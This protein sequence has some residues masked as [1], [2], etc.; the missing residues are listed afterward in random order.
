MIYFIVEL[1]VYINESTK[2]YNSNS[3]GKKSFSDIDY[4]MNHYSNN[5]DAIPESSWTMKVDENRSRTDHYK[6]DQVKE[7]N[8][9]FAYET[10]SAHWNLKE[11]LFYDLEESSENHLHQDNGFN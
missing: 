8:F 4:N 3:D 9:V 10:T 5:V 7:V 11:F 1:R 2:P 6:R